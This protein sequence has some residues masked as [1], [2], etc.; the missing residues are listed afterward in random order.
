MCGQTFVVR[1]FR[2]SSRRNRPGLIERW[3][4]DMGCALNGADVLCGGSPYRWR[5]GR[6]RRLDSVTL[7]HKAPRTATTAMTP[8]GYFR[9][10]EPP[11]AAV[12]NILR[13]RLSNS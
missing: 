3:L 4:S 8:Y 6:P 10:P 9:S 13:I 5:H 12:L 2:L 11:Q 1:H 7:S